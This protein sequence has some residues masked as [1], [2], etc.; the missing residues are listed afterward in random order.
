ML[1]HTKTKAMLIECCFCDNARDMNRYNAEN[2]ANAIVKG[3]VGQTT[4]SAP[5]KPSTS[6]NGW[7]NLDGKTGTICTPSGVNVREKK[8]TSSKILGALPNGAK[9]QLYRLEGD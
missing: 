4:S 7:V 6:D 3:L 5:S 2:M 1:K 8:S 9:V